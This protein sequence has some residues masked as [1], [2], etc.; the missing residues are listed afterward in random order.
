MEAKLVGIIYWI[1]VSFAECYW[2]RIK[3]GKLCCQERKLRWAA[4]IV[5]R[6][7]RPLCKSSKSSHWLLSRLEEGLQGAIAYRF[8]E[9]LSA[10]ELAMIHNTLGLLDAPA[11]RDY[12]ANGRLGGK[13]DKFVQGIYECSSWGVPIQTRHSSLH[14]PK[15]LAR[16]RIDCKG[17]DHL[18]FIEEADVDPETSIDCNFIA[19]AV[20][21]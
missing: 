12:Q 1:L 13:R 6:A 3:C 5:K 15:R 8:L 11:E 18:G 9:L 4:A 2:T 7:E 14:Y 20:A 16:R 19:L 17:T 21:S 10:G